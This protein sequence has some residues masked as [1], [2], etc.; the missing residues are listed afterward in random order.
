MTISFGFEFEFDVLDDRG[1]YVGH[2]CC[3]HRPLASDWDYQEDLTATVELRSPVFTNLQQAVDSIAAQFRL[4]C[5]EFPNLAPYAYNDPGR[6]LG[7]HMHVGVPDRAL[8]SRQK[9]RIGLAVAPV[10]PFLAAIHAQPIPSSRGLYSRYCYCF[11]RYFDF[12][13]NRRIPADH[14]AEISDSHLGTV[15]FRIF[16]ANIP[17]A[18]LTNAFIIT[19]IAKKFLNGGNDF[20]ANLNLSN[21]RF[22]RENALRYGLTGID[23]VKSLRYIRSILGNIALPNIASIREL[24]YLAA[25]YGINAYNVYS[26]LRINPFNYFRVMFMN[27]DKFLENLI[28]LCDDSQRSRIVRWMFEAREICTLDELIG[29][30]IAS[31]E[32]LMQRVSI[33][34][35]AAPSGVRGISRNYVRECLEGLRYHI[36]RID[37]VPGLTPHE[38]AEVI[39]DLLKRHG[40]GY[41]SVRSPDEIINERARYYV[42]FVYDSN[43]RISHILGCIAVDM[44]DGVIARLVVDRRYRRLGIGRI[45][46]NHA[47]SVLRERGNRPIRCAIRRENAASLSLFK[48]FGFRVVNGDDRCYHLV[49]D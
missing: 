6:S 47:I 19:S 41:V 21:Y 5:N 16:D 12:T 23:I 20:I 37:G 48:S 30:A 46:V 44:R 29:M 7:Q 43:A 9:T 45:L 22:E 1:N 11:T 3:F 39:A 15:E 49:L 14:Y 40:D 34:N 33:S 8:S 31:R 10:Y 42:L 13:I 18:S 4:W 24:L 26:M 32:A 36:S 2:R 27:P 25:K 35:R 38:T 28:E 17:Q